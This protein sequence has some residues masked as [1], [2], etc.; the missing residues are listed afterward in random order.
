MDKGFKL[1][2]FYKFE[3]LIDKIKNLGPN[4]KHDLNS[5]FFFNVS[6]NFYG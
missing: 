2:L 4:L 6:P 3:T 1:K 5:V